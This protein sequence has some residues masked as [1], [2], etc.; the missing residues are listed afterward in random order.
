MKRFILFTALMLLCFTALD[1]QTPRQSLIDSIA[2]T[3][4]RA[5]YSQYIYSEEKDNIEDRDAALV[6]YVTCR[7]TSEFIEAALEGVDDVEVRKLKNLLDSR[8]YCVLK[9]EMFA[10]TFSDCLHYA[11]LKECG[12]NPGFS[13]ELNDKKYAALARKLYQEFLPCMENLG[14]MTSGNFDGYGF[15]KDNA[16]KRVREALPDIFVKAMTYHLS[17][18]DLAA[19]D[20]GASDI[21]ILANHGKLWDDKEKI[22]QKL[23]EFLKEPDILDKVNEYVMGQRGSIRYLSRWAG[24]AKEIIGKDYTYKGMTIDGKPHGMGS[25]TDKKGV[26]YRG[27]F[28][29]GLRHGMISMVKPDKKPEFQLWYRGKQIKRKQ[30]VILGG[31]VFGSGQT[32]DPNT[33]SSADG[34]FID[35]RINNLGHVRTPGVEMDGLFEDGELIKGRITWKSSQ[36][37]QKSLECEYRGEG[38]VRKGIMTYVS[39]DEK[40]KKV[41]EGFFIGDKLDGPASVTINKNK[42]ETKIEGVYVKGVLWGKGKFNKVETFQGGTSEIQTYDGWFARG[43]AHGKGHAEFD[44]SELPDRAYKVKRYGVKLELHGP[45]ISKVVMEGRFEEG[46]LVEG[47]VDFSDGTFMEG[48]F[49]KGVLASGRMVKNYSDGSR[50]DGECL[51]GKFHGNGTLTYPDGDV[52]EGL[53]ENGYAVGRASEYQ[54]TADEGSRPLSPVKNRD[55]NQNKEERVF[56]FENLPVKEGVA[57]KVTVAGVKVLVRG[58]SSLDVTCKGKFDGDILSEGKVTMSDGN[59]MEGTFEDGVLVKGRARTLDKYGTVYVGEIKN[60]LPH[61]KGKCTYRNG[62]WFEGNFANGNRM[63]GTHYSADGRVIKVYEK[64]YAL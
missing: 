38:G 42:A 63:D 60:G 39:K 40:Y 50:Y 47:K 62:T 13:Y 55:K 37:K 12:D 27:D 32:R 34:F 57:R 3:L 23:M 46:R 53:F 11:Y 56:R 61:G 58:V 64:V 2:V 22:S 21:L 41:S 49:A 35:G 44:F 24:V 4:M 59:W 1:A 30:P 14:A 9:S 52:Y 29:D 43:Y 31:K 10:K 15:K 54:K 45:G 33:G 7:I 5:P 51:D 28:R 16:I 19:V 25:L 8:L 17:Y 18:E 36:W 6:E 48:T 20:I 26:V